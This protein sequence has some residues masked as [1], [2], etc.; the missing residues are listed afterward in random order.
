[1]PAASMRGTRELSGLRA[2]CAGGG[3]GRSPT[4]GNVKTPQAMPGLMV[5]VALLC[6]V[7]GCTAEIDASRAR[8]C[9]SIIPA[10]TSPDTP[11]E[12]LRTAARPDERLRVDYRLREAAGLP[13]LPPH[14]F[15]ECRFAPGSQAS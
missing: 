12:I 6:A 8:I 9:R 7:S 2:T 15:V 4:A 14:R 13:P 1:M 10:L 11:V 3:R 5:M